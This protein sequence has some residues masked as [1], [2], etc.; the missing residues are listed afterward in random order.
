MRAFTV[1]Q[2]VL[3]LHFV[4]EQLW[5]RGVSG[6]ARRPS[7]R[8]IVHTDLTE[9]EGEPTARADILHDTVSH[10][11]ELRWLGA[12]IK[13]TSTGPAHSSADIC[14]GLLQLSIAS[15]ICAGI[16]GSV[17]GGLSAAPGWLTPARRHN[18]D[19]PPQP[20]RRP[21]Q[22][23]VQTLLPI[24]TNADHVTKVVIEERLVTSRPQQPH[25]R[26]PDPGWHNWRCE[27]GSS[28]ME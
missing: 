10:S 8:E 19:S 7:V 18:D 26:S 27:P 20:P 2:V 24:L 9:L 22:L 28:H 3:A 11:T 17:L 15:A 21:P 4:W 14:S 23:P 12:S 13:N 25:W 5:I 6:K 1:H 16:L